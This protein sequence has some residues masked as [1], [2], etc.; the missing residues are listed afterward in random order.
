V[1]HVDHPERLV[2]QGEIEG[3]FVQRPTRTGPT[4]CLIS[5]QSL[6]DWNAKRKAELKK[7]MSRTELMRVLGLSRDAAMSVARAGVI[8][9]TDSLKR[10]HH[11]F[12][13]EDVLKVKHAFEQY[14][15]TSR[16]KPGSEGVTTLN[17]AILNFLGNASGLA[18]AVDAVVQGTLVPVSRTSRFPGIAGY[19]FVMTELREH[20]P[21]VH[22]QRG[23]KE[24]FNIAEAAQF[25][26]TSGAKVRALVAAR[27]FSV[28]N[29]PG[30]R[31]PKVKFIAANEVRTFARRYVSTESL[32]EEFG[33]SPRAMMGRIRGTLTPVLEIRRFKNL[34]RFVLRKD[35]ASLDTYKRAA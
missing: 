2:E 32:A 8:R 28:Q 11:L 22:R 33:I 19:I 4:L 27:V 30:K 34:A 12:F 24:F 17:E 21:F 16:P 23:P 20:S 26:K 13:R 35:A 15:L 3:V 10:G 1:E 9:Y 14:T 25:L 29:L 18:S 31:A 7:Y 5:R 6:K